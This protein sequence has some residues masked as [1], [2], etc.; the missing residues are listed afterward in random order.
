[1]SVVMT[2][3]KSSAANAI[4]YDAAR[5]E[6]HVEFGSGAVH[7]YADVSPEK[8]QAL[9]KADSIGRHLT[10]HIKGSHEHRRPA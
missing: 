2:P 7:I 8:H 5:R 10:Q 6:L 3:V 4:G 9:M 1:M